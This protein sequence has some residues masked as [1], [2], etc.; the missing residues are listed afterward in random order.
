M[1]SASSVSI[2]VLRKT[3]NGIFDFIEKDLGVTEVALK[4]NYYW[5]VAD[6]VLYAT[7]SPPKELDV[8]SLNDDWDFVLAASKSA[9]QLIPIEFIHVAPLL[10]ALAQAVPSHKSLGDV[11]KHG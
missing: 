3:I 1:S 8:G 4:Q 10:Q 7:E 2:D 11:P 9:D 5:T 6:D